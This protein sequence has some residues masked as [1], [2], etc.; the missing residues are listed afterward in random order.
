MKVYG[1]FFIHRIKRR[2]VYNECIQAQWD[3][4]GQ[5]RWQGGRLIL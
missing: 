1:I 2:P 4:G 3:E 5:T